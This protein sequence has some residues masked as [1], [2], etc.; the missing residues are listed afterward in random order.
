MV[1]FVNSLTEKETEVFTNKEGHQINGGTIP[2]DISVSGGKRVKS[3]L[4]P[5][6]P[7]Q[8]Q[9]A[10]MELTTQLH[11]GTENAHKRKQLA[12]TNLFITLGKNFC[13][14]KFAQITILQQKITYLA[15]CRNKRKLWTCYL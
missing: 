2:A 12:S 6:K 9:I 3:W 4:G 7:A 11:R 14:T 5:E 1:T 15:H 13:L 8:K 10:L